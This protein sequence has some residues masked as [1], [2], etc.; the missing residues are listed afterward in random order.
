VGPHLARL[1]NGTMS[2][3]P[4]KLRVFGLADALVVDVYHATRSF[5]TAERFGLQSQIRWAAVSGC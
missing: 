4:R 3:D 1:V 5:P 2:R